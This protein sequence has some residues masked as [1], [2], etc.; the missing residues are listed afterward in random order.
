M[1]CTAGSAPEGSRRTRHDPL[2]SILPLPVLACARVAG[3]ACLRH[4]VGAAATSGTGASYAGVEAM[5]TSFRAVQ[6][7]RDKLI[8]DSVL[9]AGVAIFIAGFGAI[10]WR[11]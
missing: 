1:C 9:L 2:P 8:Y 6:W 5:S 7:N 4:V 3:W 11:L 10:Q